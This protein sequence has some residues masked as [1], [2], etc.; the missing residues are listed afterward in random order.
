MFVHK[1]F[2][3][4][5]LISRGKLLNYSLLLH[6]DCRNLLAIRSA[7]RINP[8]VC[9]VTTPGLRHHQQLRSDL[10]SG[11][12]SVLIGSTVLGAQDLLAGQ[13]LGNV[14]AEIIAVAIA[15]WLN[16]RGKE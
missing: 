11:I 4:I 12:P 1:G 8:V 5:F 3:W 2:L 10:C 13:A 6:I 9:R 15:L 14:L 7:A 16:K